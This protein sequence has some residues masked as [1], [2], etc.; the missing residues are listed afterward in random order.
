MKLVAGQF[1]ELNVI[2]DLRSLVGLIYEASIG[3]QSGKI[4]CAS[5]TGDIK[6]AGG[7]DRV[8]DERARQQLEDNLLAWFFI[9]LK[10]CEK[11]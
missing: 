11:F 10:I 3:N 5:K 9:D 4:E 7:H 2:S 6:Y 8:H 1:N